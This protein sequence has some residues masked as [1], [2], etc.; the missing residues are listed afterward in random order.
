MSPPPTPL[1]WL[2]PQPS[3]AELPT[4]L[5]DPF[6]GVEPHPLARRCAEAL[7]EELRT[8]EIAPGIP[9]SLL[10]RR[11]EGGKMF[12]V[13]AVADGAGRVGWMRAV[14][15]QVDRIWNLP[16]WAPALFDPAERDAVEPPIEQAV[17]ALT[18][19]VEQARNDPALAAAQQALA[20]LE[21][22]HAH[23]REALRTH[24]LTRRAERKAERD[25]SPSP[26]RLHALAQESRGDEA[27]R[28]R[29][30]AAWGVEHEACAAGLKRLV[31]RVAALERLRR[32]FSRRAMR[33]I[34]DAYALTSFSGERV[35]LRTLFPA[36]DPPSGASDCAA[37][38]LLAAAQRQG[39][40]PLA[41][42]E[43]WWG[44]PPPGGGRVQG[45]Y[46]PACTPKCGP[47][48][49]FLLRGLPV[50][51][52]RVF[53]PPERERL[54]LRLVLRDARFVVVE[55]PEGLLSVPAKESSIDDCV[56]ARIRAQFPGAE[57]PMAVHRLDLDT[58]G[59]LLVALDGEAYRL[60]Q[61]QF[62]ER[63]VHKQYVALL[64][65]AL[66][67]EGGRIEL[68]LRVD[69]DQRPRQLVDRVHGKPASTQWKRLGIEG[70]RTRVAL[71]P[72]TG[73]T[74]Q[75]RVHCAH[76]EGLGIPIVGDRLYG[77][78]DTR[79]ML[80][81]SGLRFR[82]PFTGSTVRVSLD[83]PF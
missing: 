64:E 76:P 65:G 20:A 56:L 3:P 12:G 43:F 27:E 57:A 22:E 38:K 33:H 29:Q 23:R 62:L 34:W 32:A 7:M 15:G 1:H 69:L 39:L 78:P 6:D 24:Q 55:K 68:P 52:R 60:L 21:S 13:L 35:L 41:L 36:G 40:R 28:K 47:V 83:A 2:E 45:S 48:L 30:E 8:G 66:Q 46:F 44:P 26:E 17:K 79:L 74:H 73:R 71:F 80:H 5:P 25:G 14:S 19:R 50:A 70:G 77:Q 9:T 81:A 75:L 61:A 16:G 82:H 4:G 54:P 49:P 31:R 59:L 18:A 72:L 37:P 10:E 51:P 67:G 58:S 53:R 11:E 63:T 42:A